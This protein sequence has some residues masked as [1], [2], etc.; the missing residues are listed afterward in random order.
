MNLFKSLTDKTVIKKIGTVG[1]SA[2]KLYCFF[3]VAKT[4][5]LPLNLV[6]AQGVSMEP[7][8]RNNDILITEKVSVRRQH[9]KTYFIFASS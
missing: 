7:L 2:T 4:Y 5:I 6:V 1:W 8:I 3:H 9:L